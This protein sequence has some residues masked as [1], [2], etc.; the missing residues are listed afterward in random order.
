MLVGYRVRAD[1]FDIGA[2]PES[3]SINPDEVS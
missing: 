3:G 2:D 1:A